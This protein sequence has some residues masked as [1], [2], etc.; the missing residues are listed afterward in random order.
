VAAGAVV[1]AMIVLGII[2]ILLAPSPNPNCTDPRCHKVSNS[3]PLGAPHRYTSK[4]LGYSVEYYDHPEYKGAVKITAQDDKS[5]A[6]QIGSFPWVINGDKVSGRNSQQVVEGIQ[7]QRF[8]DAQYLY[9]IPGVTFGVTPG[10]GNVYR[11]ALKNSGGQT[12]EARMVVAAAVK[13][14]IAIELIMIG[15]YVKSTKDDGHPNPSNTPLS[16]LADETLKL[17]YW[18][19]DPEL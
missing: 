13:N 2:A 4:A 3:P 18:P 9:T 17:V 14:D 15:P 7:Q 10:Y 19:G 11:V 6:W 16:P 12:V 5:I 1:F 8:A